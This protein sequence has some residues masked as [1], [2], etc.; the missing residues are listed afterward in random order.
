[1]VEKDS[2]NQAARPLWIAS[3]KMAAF[4]WITPLAQL[5]AFAPLEAVEVHKGYNGLDA[6]AQKASRQI[7]GALRHRSRRFSPCCPCLPSP[8]VCPVILDA[9]FLEAGIQVE[10]ESHRFAASRHL[11]YDFVPFERRG[12]NFKGTAGSPGANGSSSAV[13]HWSNRVISPPSSFEGLK[14]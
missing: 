14:D 12:V 8:Q 13:R 2:S 1:M 11:A 7:A 9:A 3:A 5:R 10:H 6:I 4:P